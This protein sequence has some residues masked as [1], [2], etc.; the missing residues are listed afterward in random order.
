MAEGPKAAPTTDAASAY[1][2]AG[3]RYDVLDAG[4]RAALAA[5]AA[6]APGRLAALGGAPVM[7]SQGEPAFVVRLPGVTL[8]SV[9]ECLGTKSVLARRYQ[10]EGGEGRFRDVGFDA[11][12]AI[13]NDLACVGALP[14]VVHAYF[15]TGAAG[16]YAD[17][18]RFAELVRGWREACEVAGAVWGGGESPTLPGLVAEADIELAG[19]AVGVVPGAEPILGADLA[20]G[21]E[22]VLV[23]STGLHANGASL[24]RAVAGALPEGL[25]TPLPSGVELGAALLAPSALYVPLVARLLEAGGVRVTYL[26]HITGHGLR[27]VMRADRDLTYRLSALPPVPEVLAELARRAG[28]DDRAAYGTLNMGVGLVACVRP[29]GGAEA[30]RLAAAC[31]LP[32][33]VGGVVEE[34]PRRVVLEP[35]GVTYAAGELALRS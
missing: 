10:E 19:S 29:G 15:A 16:W 8:A 13:V 4:K 24:A 20:P 11:V 34:G 33:L 6:T 26:S 23:A 7:A 35:L 21:D 32:A 31:G 30:V 22:L 25:R 12:A 14:L 5:A 9:L 3:V 1:D 28:M 17:E 27:K 2:A 18:A